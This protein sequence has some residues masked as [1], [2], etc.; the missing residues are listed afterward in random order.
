M[1]KLYACILF[2]N[3]GSHLNIRLTHAEIGRQFIKTVKELNT[4][5]FSTFIISMPFLSPPGTH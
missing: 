3:K 5:L 4:L 1:M 2:W